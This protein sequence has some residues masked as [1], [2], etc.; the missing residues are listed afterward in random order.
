MSWDLEPLSIEI[1]NFECKKN[2]QNQNQQ[3][4]SQIKFLVKSYIII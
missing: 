3:Q 4:Y 1:K 2:T